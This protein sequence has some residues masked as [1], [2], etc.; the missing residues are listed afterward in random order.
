[1]D[2]SHLNALELGLSHERSRLANAQSQGER[3]LRE[4]WV[5]QLEKEVKAERE[6]LGLTFEPTEM[7]ADELLAALQA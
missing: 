4:V 3:E 7:T 5:R 2:C 6:F 1:M